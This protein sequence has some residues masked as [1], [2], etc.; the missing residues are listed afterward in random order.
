[1]GTGR[2]QMAY[3]MTQLESQADKPMIVLL[4]E[5]GMMGEESL[6]GVIDVLKKLYRKGKLLQALIVERKTNKKVISVL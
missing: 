2:G 5:V 3:L 1:M 6:N 4:D